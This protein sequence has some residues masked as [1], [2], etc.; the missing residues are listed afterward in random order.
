MVVPRNLTAHTT[1]LSQSRPSAAQCLQGGLLL[2]HSGCPTGTAW[3]PVLG[4]VV[5][6]T[7]HE[8]GHYSWLVGVSPGWGYTRLL[9][10][11]VVA[12]GRPLHGPGRPLQPWRH[13][14]GMAPADLSN[15]HQ[16]ALGSAGGSISNPPT[17]SSRFQRQMCSINGANARH[18]T[19]SPPCPFL[20][21]KSLSL[22]MF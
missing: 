3:S 19:R 20:H 10:P 5:R 15:K 2:R 14:D 13:R 12:Q 6:Y 17:L 7:H 21:V 8:G 16:E 1:A 11:S 22:L 18:R 4:G 9:W